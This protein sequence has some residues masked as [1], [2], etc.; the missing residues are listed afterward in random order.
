[1]LF[2]SISAGQRLI[3]NIWKEK[4]AGPM[5]F[6]HM[7]YGIGSCSV[8]LYSSPFLAIPMSTAPVNITNA[9]IEAHLDIMVQNDSTANSGFNANYGTS[10]NIH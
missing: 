7:G 8:S 2:K 1:M 9:S 5:H 10:K 6:L 4:S 3:F